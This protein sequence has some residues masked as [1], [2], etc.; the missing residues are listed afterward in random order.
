MLELPDDIAAFVAS[1]PDDEAVTLAQAIEMEREAARWEEI[2]ETFPWPDRGSWPYDYEPALAWREATA[3]LIDEEPSLGVAAKAWYATRPRE[4]INH[5]AMTYDPRNAGS[6]DGPPAWLPLLTFPKQD[7]LIEFLLYCL[8][9]VVH[10]LI[11]KSRDMGATWV[12]CAVSVWLWLFYDGASV[13]WGSRVED[14]VDRLGDMDSIFEKIRTIIDALPDAFKPDGLVPKEHLTFMKSI[15][16]ETGNTITGEGGDNIGRGGRKLIY[17]KDESAHY[18][19][20]E[21]IEA[22]LS[23]NT[24]VAIDISSVNGLGNVFH[25]TRESGELWAPGKKIEPGKTAVFVMDWSDHPAKTR[26]WYDQEKKRAEERGLAHIFAQEVERNYSAAVEGTIIPADWVRSAIDAHIVLGIEDRGPWYGALDVADGGG[27]VNAS[28]FRRGII[29]KST[30]SWGA[31]DTGETTRRF[32]EQA[33]GKGHI[34]LEYDCIGVGSGVKAETNRL[35]DEGL[36]SPLLR[37]VPWNASANPLNPD[38][39]VIPDDRDSALNRDFYENL[40]AQGWWELRLRFERTH[41]AVQAKKAGEVLEFDPDTLISIPS[42]LPQL[43]QI[44]KELSQPTATKSLRTGKLVVNKTPEGTRSPNLGDA[45]VMAYHPAG[46]LAPVI[47]IAKDQF[48][49]PPFKLPPHFRK[50]F[51]MRVEG[52]TV[53]ALWGA[54]DPN[55]DILYFTTEYSRE[56]AEPAVHALAIGARGKWIPG[57][58]DCDV[59][60]LKQFD[61]LMRVYV[62][63]LQQQ[64]HVVKGADGSRLATIRLTAADRAVEAGISELQQRISTGRCQVFSTCGGFFTDYRNYRRDDEGAIVGGGLMDCARL[65]AR[66]EAI[67]RMIVEPSTQ[68]L[69]SNSPSGSNPYV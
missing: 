6:V 23:A 9:N 67:R 58:F 42:D 68:M 35:A 52:Q 10:G 56:Y 69:N 18:P 62:T 13:G 26:A 57:T 33:E 27:D 2:A 60:N 30:D 66:P 59:T 19:R 17:F 14:L 7:E 16:P 55:S 41:R 39:P 38:E 3:A 37:I 64:S 43:R 53:R 65:L 47:S 15:N 5:W 36:L 12:S 49:V 11:E 50:G 34:E 54:Y 1:L 40:K 63:A 25:R 22:A 61:E 20:P 32:V 21:K 51:A 29:L 48:A 28:A 8:A 45:I 4:F 44:E 31:R 24:R 46:G